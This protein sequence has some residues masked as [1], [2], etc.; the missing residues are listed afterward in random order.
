M[1]GGVVNFVLWLLGLFLK[2]PAGPSQEAQAEG[3]AASAETKVA[4]GNAANAEL[5]AA[6]AARADADAQ[7]VRLDPHGNDVV[8]DPA[9]PINNLP[10]EH[11]RD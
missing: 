10:S 3:R 5:V 7:R 9:S 1:I 4:E 8:T 11:F 6:A 2:K